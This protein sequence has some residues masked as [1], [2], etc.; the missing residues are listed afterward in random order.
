MQRLQLNLQLKNDRSQVKNTDG[1]T[2]QISEK[3]GSNILPWD[4]KVSAFISR[5]LKKKNI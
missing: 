2:F 3:T 4:D 1:R 5:V